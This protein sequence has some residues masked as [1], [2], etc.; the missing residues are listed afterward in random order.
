MVISKI[1][2]IFTEQIKT[3]TMNGIFTSVW[4]GGSQ[5]STSAEL[6]E[7][8]GEV[9]T[10]SVDVEK[11]DL[12]N[13]D[14]EYFTDDNGKEYSICPTCHTFIMKTIMVDG[15]GSCYDEK[16]VCSD[17]DCENGENNLELFD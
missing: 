15:I 6:N 12:E 14:E 2:I 17:P 16:T 11:F 5:I 7:I 4:D 1:G 8:T 10:Q 3:K 13:L 9:S